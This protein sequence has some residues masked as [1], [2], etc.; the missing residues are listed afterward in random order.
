M[1]SPSLR[2]GY[3]LGADGPFMTAMIERTADV[4]FSAPL[5]VQEMASHLLDT[6]ITEQLRSV[7]AGYREKALAVRSAIESNL[8]PWL[9][10]ARGGSAGFYFYLTFRE[11]ETH[12]ASPF[13][14]FLTRTTGDENVDGPAGNRRPRVIY[15]PGEHCVH[16]QGDLA[17]RGRRQLRLSYGFEDT[18]V[19]VRALEL[20]REAAEYAQ[21]RALTATQTAL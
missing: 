14:R 12:S 1:L 7:N 8:G 20:M 6:G 13:F 15:I 11:I 9:E 3:L 10:A 19:M 2:I 5:F 17:L 4:G 21:S 16:A 18:P